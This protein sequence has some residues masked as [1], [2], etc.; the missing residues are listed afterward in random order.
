M[1]G[2]THAPH[3][4]LLPDEADDDLHR[5]V[6]QNRHQPSAEWSAEAWNR[7]GS[8]SRAVVHAASH[9]ARAPNILDSRAIRDARWERGESQMPTSDN[10]ARGSGSRNSRGRNR[11]S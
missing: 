4:G 1:P 6:R 5:I 8:D 7:L 9:N 3:P 10:G 2:L 11:R